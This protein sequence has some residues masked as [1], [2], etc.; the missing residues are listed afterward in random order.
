MK[1][2]TDYPLEILSQDERLSRV[3]QGK[4]G[5]CCLQLWI[6]DLLK[7]ETQEFHLLYGWIIPT[8][9]TQKGWASPKDGGKKRKLLSGTEKYRV[10]KLTL[11]ECADNIH[12]LVEKL[13]QGMTLGEACQ[14]V[15]INQVAEAYTRFRLVDYAKKFAVRPIIFQPSKNSVSDFKFKPDARPM[16][17]PSS[18]NPAFVGTLFCIN[19]TPFFS[20]NKEI[21]TYCLEEL[22]RDTGLRFFDTDSGRMGNIEW[23]AFPSADDN[24][25]P[26]ITVKTNKTD[27]LIDENAEDGRKEHS[28]RSVTTEIRGGVFEKETEIL[29]RCRLSNDNAVISDQCRNIEIRDNNPILTDFEAAEDISEILLTIWKKEKGQ[30][31]WEI[32]HEDYTPL[33]R[34][35][36][37]RA[38]IIELEGKLG[39]PHLEKITDRGLIRRVDQVQRIKYISEASKG[40]IDNYPFDPWIPSARTA[41]EIASQMF[42]KP[43]GGHFFAKGWCGEGRLS[44]IEW[45][46]SLDKSK[47][48]EANKLYVFDPY[49]DESGI[50]IFARMESVSLECIVLTN[51]QALNDPQERVRRLKKICCE[52][53]L[54][55]NYTNFSLFDLRKK[56]KEKQVFHDRHILMADQTGR[57]LKGYHLSNSIQKAT[58][59][60]PLLVTPVPDDLF[61][62]LETYISDL[63]DESKGDREIV[64]IFSPRDRQEDRLSEQSHFLSNLFQRYGAAFFESDEA[65]FT[66][67]INHLKSLDT[68]D[69][70]ELWSALCEGLR[71]SQTSEQDFRTIL[72]LTDTQFAKKIRTF[73]S[74]AYLEEPPFGTSAVKITPE[75]GGILYLLRKNDFDKVL[76]H[77]GYYFTHPIRKYYALSS[78]LW[79]IRFLMKLDPELLSEFFSDAVRLLL[80]SEPDAQNDLNP[81]TQALGVLF[82]CVVTE[83]AEELSDGDEKLLKSF[84]R[85]DIPLGRAIAVQSLL[86]MPLESDDSHFKY[87]MTLLSELEKEECLHAL[88]EWGFKLRVSVNQHNFQETEELKR[89]RLDVFEEMKTLWPEQM[90]QE[91]LREIA[92]CLSGPLEGAWAGSTT[93]DLLIPLLNMKKLELRQIRELWFSILLEHVEKDFSEYADVP[94]TETCGWALAYSFGEEYLSC[95]KQLEDIMRIKQRTLEKPFSQ[96][97]DYSAW[98][99]SRNALIW[100]Q[101]LFKQTKL[102][103]LLE[104]E[105]HPEFETIDGKIQGIEDILSPYDSQ[106]ITC[107]GLERFASA[108]QERIENEILKTK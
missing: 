93:N 91:E 66:R 87:A 52:L 97:I 73:L 86:V 102:Y 25:N 82:Q 108:V 89:L 104:T 10:A 22:Q 74:G 57:I 37:F 70:R 84:L 92:A 71:S 68:K 43:S 95:M 106:K 62:D 24:D 44:F 17:S 28:C 46:Q 61:D 26:Y 42:P 33:I 45:L 13:L 90:T 56:G 35:I 50:E 96:S 83:V 53:E 48:P 9:R 54:L 101:T 51:T 5:S 11:I 49:F 79:S 105:R 39:S 98:D 38:G 1:E 65:Y 99:T 81:E 72:K 23:F 34:R 63:L 85:C 8:S 58:Q 88:A 12:L 41:R 75:T 36:G 64:T 31:C 3:F 78:V 2:Q 76:D 27:R 16:T 77:A 55:L 14:N 103:M 19:K 60:H 4:A 47:P 29:V 67:I 59:N 94:L 107:Q 20:Y 30:S 15:G 21:I 40:E 69:F 100:I 80:K 6:L 18:R 32:W 7:G